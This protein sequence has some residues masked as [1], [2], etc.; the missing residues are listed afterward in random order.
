MTAPHR[1]AGRPARPGGRRG[2]RRPGA[3]QPRHRHPLGVLRRLGGRGGQRRRRA[4][5][6]RPVAALRVS[7]GDRRERHL[8]VSHHSLTAYGRVALARGPG[9]RAGAARRVRRAGRPS[10]PSRWPPARA[11]RRCRWTACTRRCATRRCGC[12]RWAGAWT[13]TWPTSWPRPPPGR[14]RGLAAVVE[15]LEGERPRAGALGPEQLQALHALGQRRHRA[16]SGIHHITM[17]GSA[18]RRNHSLRRCRTP[19]CALR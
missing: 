10:R 8:G 15:L 5:A 11:G 17:Y 12:R 6:G 1:A 3:G 19:R 4:A 7:E 2:D 14:P 9:G 18:M 16:P 13:R